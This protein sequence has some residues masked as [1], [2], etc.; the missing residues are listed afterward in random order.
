LP[1]RLLQHCA[2][3]LAVLAAASSH[4][5]T[6]QSA[7]SDKAPFSFTIQRG[8][9]TTAAL[10]ADGNG[11]LLG[12][13]RLGGGYGQVFEIRPPAA[14]ETAWTEAFLHSF[15]GTD[16]NYPFAGLIADRAG[17]LYGTTS[18]GGANNEGVAFELSPPPAGKNA[19]T[20]HVLHS[21]GGLDGRDPIAG[22]VADSAGNLYGTTAF[23]GAGPVLGCGVVFELAPQA[24]GTA[25]IESVLHSFNCIDGFQPQSGLIA[26]D[27]GNLYGTTYLGGANNDG[28]VF[29]LS[30]PAAGETAWTL[31]V[32]FSFNK[33]DGLNPQA[34]LIADGEGDLFGTT[35]AGGV[36]GEGV[37]FELRPPARMGK[38]WT[39]RVLYSFDQTKGSNPAASLL[40]D[41]L[42][43]LYGTTVYG[44]M[45]GDGV[46]FEL[47]PPAAGK[48][49]WTEKVLHSF[50]GPRGANPGA[51][52]ITDG[53][54]NL[55]GT[56]ENGGSR[57]RGV[58]F[59]LTP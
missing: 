51:N 7:P 36:Y 25:W 44:G 4:A 58:V 59:R 17:N 22:V 34:G 15:T 20:E 21:F 39:E 12:T 42:G 10:L 50:N 48:K 30:P 3:T 26:D 49:S 8:G 46:V 33:D 43:N 37:V 40:A 47:S 19:W 28:G 23:G 52:L 54:G 9:Q 31:T 16:G 5:A 14:G 57:D 53:S 11:N 41:G 38:A 6:R 55:F 45:N 1:G 13:T 56:A 24:G 35:Y 2:T 18:M 32:L 29:E 27:S